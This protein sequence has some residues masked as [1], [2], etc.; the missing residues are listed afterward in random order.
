MTL[1]NLKV[2]Q[3]LQ[4]DKLDLTVTEGICDLITTYGRHLHW[5]IEG[6]GG[7]N[8]RLY[9]YGIMYTNTQY[10]CVIKLIVFISFTCTLLHKFMQIIFPCSKHQQAL[11]RPS[12]RDEKAYSILMTLS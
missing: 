6:G 3:P 8:L 7:A 12:K 1:N 10:I 9:L 2:L 11:G 4:S 5:K